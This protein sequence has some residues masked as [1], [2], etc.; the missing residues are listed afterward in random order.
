LS[1]FEFELLYM[2]SV[3]SQVVKPACVNAALINKVSKFVV[4]HLSQDR[5]YV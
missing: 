5:F 1:R 3:R 4:M 2:F